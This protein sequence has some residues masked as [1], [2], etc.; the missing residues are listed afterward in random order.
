MRIE[1]DY[2]VGDKVVVKNIGEIGTVIRVDRPQFNYLVKFDNSRY[3]TCTYYE[4]ELQ[5]IN[6]TFIP[7]DIQPLEIHEEGEPVTEGEDN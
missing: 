5:D 3:T 6:D 4:D 7:D 1:S 2:K